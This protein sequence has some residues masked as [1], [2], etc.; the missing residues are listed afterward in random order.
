MLYK[1]TVTGSGSR[2]L[3]PIGFLNFAG[4]GLAASICGGPASSDSA[5]TR[6]QGPAWS[7]AAVSA[8]YLRFAK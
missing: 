2:D 6:R 7:V 8:T 5:H 3:S 4:M 1:L